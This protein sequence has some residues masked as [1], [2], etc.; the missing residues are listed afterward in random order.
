[1]DELDT[2]GTAV[3]IQDL[4]AVRDKVEDL[5]ARR[6]P[7]D[8]IGPKAELRDVGDAFR[9]LLEVPGVDQEDLEV[10]VQGREL[11]VAGHRQADGNGEAVFSERW[12]GPFQRTV[13]LP[14]DVD[15]EGATALLVA[16]LLILHLPKR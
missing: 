15:P 13:E 9:L 4:I 11:V 2:Y 5:L 1:M 16:G 3:D 8:A 14:A 10:A 7:G 6:I 12:V